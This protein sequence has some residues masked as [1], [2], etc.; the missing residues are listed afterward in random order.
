VLHRD[1]SKKNAM[2]NF[3][4][5]LLQLAL[6]VAGALLSSAVGLLS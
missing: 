1:P 6:L 4:A 3:F 2:G 5:S